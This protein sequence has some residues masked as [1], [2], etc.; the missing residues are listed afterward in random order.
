LAEKDWQGLHSAVHKMIP[1]FAIMGISSDFE[2]MARKVQDYATTQEQA[3][4]ISE[5]VIQLGN[6]C[7]Q[8]CKE[9]EEE[10]IKIKDKK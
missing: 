5:M 4:G 8:A 1:S 2:N 10:F 9:L 7:T 6:I 3:E